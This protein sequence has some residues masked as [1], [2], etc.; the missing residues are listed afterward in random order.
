MSKRRAKPGWKRWFGLALAAVLILSVSVG[1][2]AQKNKKNKNTDSSSTAADQTG[3]P[4]ISG[5]VF[6]QI[7]RDIG[8]MLGAFQLGNIDLMHKH[9]ADNATFVSG[10]YAPPVVGWAN[11]LPIYQRERAEFQGMQVIRRNTYIY[12]HADAA[13][14]SYQWEFEIDAERAAVHGARPDNARI[15]EGGRQLANRAQPHVGDLSGRG[16][17]ANVCCS[18]VPSASYESSEPNSKAVTPRFVTD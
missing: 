3:Q 7:D 16:I 10:A 14:A 13:W 5:S 17:A 11:Y 12:T 1:A 2:W 15:H 8:E 9:Y 4:A 18:T 6:D